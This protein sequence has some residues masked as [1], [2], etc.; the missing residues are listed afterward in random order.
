M[1]GSYNHAT[2]EDGSLRSPETMSNA[3]ETSGDAFETIEEL[4]GMIWWLA[5]SNSE[6]FE[7]ATGLVEVARQSYME[8]LANAPQTKGTP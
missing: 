1:A 5:T 4:Y 7:E 6:T 3:T 2:N 8:G